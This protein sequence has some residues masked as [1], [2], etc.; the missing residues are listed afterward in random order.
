[1]KKKVKKK[2][3]VPTLLELSKE[4]RTKPRLVWHPIE[5]RWQST[6]EKFP[7]NMI[8][9][10][11]L[12]SFNILLDAVQEVITVLGPKA[13]HCLSD[14]E[15]CEY[16]WTTA[17]NA[18]YDAFIKLGIEHQYNNHPVF[19]ETKKRLLKWQKQNKTEK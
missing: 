4:L 18:C 13:P 9:M 19:K 10:V 7:G 15:G 6:T 16:E 8:P 1:M 11:S 2:P 5:K 3:K 14:C 17:L 12:S